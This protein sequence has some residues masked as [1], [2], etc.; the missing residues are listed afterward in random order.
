MCFGPQMYGQK[1]SLESSGN[2]LSRGEGQRAMVQNQYH[3][4]IGAP[5]ILPILGMFTGGS[6]F[7]PMAK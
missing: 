6:G 4:G 1:V 2:M 7:G 5:P 3:I